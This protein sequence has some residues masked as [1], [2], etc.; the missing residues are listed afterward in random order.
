MDGTENECYS[1]CISPP[2]DVTA[3]TLQH[4]D[5]TADGRYRYRKLQHMD[6]T[7]D[8]CDRYRTLVQLI[9]TTAV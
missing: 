9:D 8:G 5:F 3:R 1:T 6:I 2:M 4:M 7:A